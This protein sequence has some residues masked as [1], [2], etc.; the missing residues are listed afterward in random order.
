MLK[1]EF[2]ESVSPAFPKMPLAFAQAAPLGTSAGGRLRRLVTLLYCLYGASLAAPIWLTSH[3]PTEDGPAHQ[4]WTEVYRSLGDTQSPFQPYYERSVHWNTPN[5][6]Y[7]ALQLGLSRYLDPAT[8]QRLIITVL[9]MLWMGATAFLSRTVS[10]RLTMGSFAALLLFHGWALYVGLFSFLL[11]IPILVTAAG[12]LLRLLS[13]WSDPSSS[14]SGSITDQ[15][16]L[17]VLGV[18]AYYSHLVD[19]AIFVLL[20]GIAGAWNYR[21][22]SRGLRLLLPAA[23]VCALLLTYL[24]SNSF[25]G[26]GL[27]WWGHGRTVK[28]FLGLAFW[29]GLASDGIGFQAT[30]GALAL[31]LSL[32][33]IASLRAW[34]AGTLPASRRLMLVV[35]GCLAVGYVLVPGAVGAGGFFKERIQLAMWALVLP[36]LSANMSR[37]LQALALTALMAAGA[38]QLIDFTGRAHRFG[39]EYSALLQQA[40]GLRPGSLV[41]FDQ[42]AD[43]SKFEGSFLSPLLEGGAIAARCHCIWLGG[44]H[45]GT[46]FYWIRARG[47]Q[48]SRADFVLR[49]RDRSEQDADGTRPTRLSLLVQ[50]TDTSPSSR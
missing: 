41:R 42:P 37:R 44:S 46:P 47:D 15:V 29:Q 18:L 27:S 49:I 48:S 35:G 8:A 43:K 45:P 20:L 11:G 34:L 26:G 5:L 10:G 14:K 3:F 22:P 28:S 21:Q 17:A 12:V 25:G 31:A 30:R 6:S 19:G 4:Y 2:T 9:L 38:W 40:D 7:F 33:L 36:T 32:L 1:P 13:R 23:P 16:L 39:R 24:A 50:A